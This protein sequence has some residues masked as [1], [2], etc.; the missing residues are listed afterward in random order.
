M[1]RGLIA[2]SIAAQISRSEA[3]GRHHIMT[4]LPTTS[5]ACGRTWAR[6]TTTPRLLTTQ[7]APML[8]AAGQRIG[9]ARVS[10]Q[11]ARG[12]QHIETTKAS[13][14]AV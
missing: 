1:A 13:T 6:G 11:E 3:R 10:E 14:A 12:L 7:D 9:A 2:C 5:V 4:P 8:I